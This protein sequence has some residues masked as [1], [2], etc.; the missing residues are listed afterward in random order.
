MTRLPRDVSGQQCVRALGRAGFAV[1]R[2]TGSH[3]I[4]WRDKP[5]TVLPV[6]NHR[7]LKP[8]MLRHIIREAGL[9]VEEFVEL[10][11]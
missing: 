3:I 2:Q 1:T 6:P 10:L 5:P 7:T 9:T 11:R 4:M 8:G